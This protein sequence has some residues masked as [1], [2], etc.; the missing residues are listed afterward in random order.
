MAKILIVEK[1]NVLLTDEEFNILTNYFEGF[2]SGKNNLFITGEEF[3][4]TINYCY[5]IN[6][7]VQEEF[8]KQVRKEV[9]NFN[10]KKG[11]I[12]IN[13]YRY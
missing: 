2:A 13:F 1:M 11:N 4:N 3:L 12:D 6:P 5:Q 10:S 9:E 8:I 7:I